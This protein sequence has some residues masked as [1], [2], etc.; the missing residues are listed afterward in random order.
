MI[1][2]E[3]DIPKLTNSLKR[4]AKAFGDTN[5]TGVARLGVQVCR[6]VAVSTQVHGKSGAKKKQENAIEKGVNAVIAIVTDK[7]FRLLQSGKRKNA[8]IRNRWVQ[9]ETARLLPDVERCHEWIES[10]RGPKGHTPRLDQFN[11]GVAPKSVVLKVIRA[12]KARA[13]IA[14]G[15][16]IGAGMAIARKQTGAQR[17]NIGRNFLGYAQ[18]HSSRGRARA[19]AD[20]FNPIAYLINESRHTSSG[21]VMRP[22]DTERALGFGL[23]KTIAWYR[24]AAKKAI[25]QS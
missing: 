19:T 10:H 22:A 23:R 6:E 13:G 3:F 2:A 7:E 21:Y 18:K 8:K 5:K 20:P 24:H 15:G 11:I 4:A 16:W 25:D 17:I 14:K 1:K 12:R 9:V